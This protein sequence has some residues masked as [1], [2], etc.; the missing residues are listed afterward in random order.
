MTRTLR[1][2]WLL[3]FSAFST[4]VSQQAH[5]THAIGSDMNYLNVS[6]GVYV[7]QY[8]FYRDCSGTTAPASFSLSYVGRLCGAN[9]TG[10]NTG[11]TVT[12]PL[13][14]SQTG[15]PYC[16][17]QN[18]RSV[19]SN[20][21]PTTTDRPN[22][23]VYT[24]SATLNL[25]TNA[26]ASCSEWRLSTTLALRPDVENLTD[27]GNLYSFLYLNNRDVVG[28]NSP[29]FPLGQG[30]KP[31]IYSCDSTTQTI[32][33]G[34]V[35]QENDSLV[36]TLAPAYEDT[37]GPFPSTQ[38]QATYTAPFT[39][40]NPIRTLTTPGSL[41]FTLDRNTG[42]LSFTA[43]AALPTPLQ[44]ADP[45]NKF[46]VVIQVDAYRRLPSGRR[47]RTATV[48]R[49]ILLTIFACDDRPSPP[50]PPLPGDTAI[51]NVTL[52][53]TLRVTVADTVE[54]DACAPAQISFNIIDLNGDSI[55]VNVP[56]NQLPGTSLVQIS[57]YRYNPTVFSSLTATLRW[58]PDSAQVNQFYRITF[59]ISDDGCPIP[60]FTS[61]TLTLKVIK[62]EFA[63][64][65]LQSQTAAGADDTVCLGQ[66]TTLIAK[67]RRP[68]LYGI[69]PMPAT[70]R[71]RWAPNPSIER[72][73][74][75]T[76]IV[77]PR[78]TTRYQ[79]EVVSPQG[80][81][82]TA[83]VLVVVDP[84][85]VARATTQTDTTCLGGTAQLTATPR[86]RTIGPDGRPIIYT[87]QWQPNPTLSDTTSATPVARPL[88]DTR[89]RVRV[90]S[91]LG[92]VDT[93]SVVVRVNRANVASATSDVLN[94]AVCRRGI[95]QLTA[96]P[97]AATTAPNGQTIVYTY[98]WQRDSTLSDTTSKTPTARPFQTT[99]YRVRVLS[100]YGC[101]DTASV[102]V[103]VDP[104][105]VASVTKVN[106]AP[107]AVGCPGTQ[108]L[109]QATSRPETRNAAGQLINYTYQWRPD[110]TLSATNVANPTVTP[111]ANTSRR[112]FVTVFSDAGCT[113]TASVV[114]RTD[115]LPTTPQI[116]DP[117]GTAYPTVTLG[118]G[119]TPLDVRAGND[120]G[121]FTYTFTP[122][123]GLN[124]P[125][126]A[127]PTVSGLTEVTTY[128][129]RIR[130]A[131]D[132][133][134]ERT[135]TVNV[136][137][138]IWNIITPNNDGKNDRFELL[139]TAGVELK[140]FNRWGREVYSKKPYDNTWDGQDLPNGTYYYL[141]TEPSGKTFKGWVQVVR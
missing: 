33:S 108:V 26:N 58:S 111:V 71:Y 51:T 46:V 91:S 122:T 90:L 17:D 100:S 88:Q 63:A 6:P 77:R 135:L 62:R 32:G 68:A 64:I 9:G 134:V 83:S 107:N 95:T 39:P 37:P 52:D 94:A 89:Y 40:T 14:N 45:N 41:P 139:G 11:S 121:T 127:T 104:T 130:T 76:A 110:P 86:A 20:S 84:T 141:V 49:D 65:G 129:I 29:A 109:L 31:L 55:I 53:S 38:G 8:R 66:R 133:F 18:I 74:G 69:P 80:C 61:F 5:A 7:V 24:Y 67:T 79:V 22:Y 48:R 82:D 112:Y 12:L 47:V 15:N 93:A 13:L 87:F 97:R 36:Y 105:N 128:T 75:D 16:R 120:D 106:V 35:D 103:R 50:L 54:V 44:S 3:L 116:T 92:C 23:Q 140:V 28:D 30:F 60:T 125:N 81:V 56:P 99:R 21:G 72:I 27:E 138:Q 57:N 124:N 4:L 126:S 43:G 114:I 102:V 19:C 10:I 85:N 1:L 137:L 131:N 25:G 132:C 59:N 42:N 98:R 34:V 78:V 96:V 70:Y 73:N 123:T 113:D 117:Q 2:W 101:T 136:P 118:T 119:G 115:A